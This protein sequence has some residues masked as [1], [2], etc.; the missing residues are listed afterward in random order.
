MLDNKLKLGSVEYIDSTEE[1]GTILSQSV[2]AMA[3]V[4]VGTEIS[5][6]VS[7]GSKKV[8]D[9]EASEN[10]VGDETRE[11]EENGDLFDDIG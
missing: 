7:R 2:A 4:P 6:K 9:E 5:F 1:K 3:T 10:E 11:D 8:V